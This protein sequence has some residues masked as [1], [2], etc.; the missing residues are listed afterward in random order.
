MHRYLRAWRERG[1][2]TAFQARIVNYADDFV[3]LSRGRATQALTWTRWGLAH[4]GLELSAE[5]TR[6]CNARRDGFD[7]LG[8]TFGPAHFRKDG[9]RY[10]AAQPARRA[11][12][13]LKE[14]VRAVLRAGIVSPWAEVRD[15]LNR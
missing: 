7:F 3:I 11:V 10:L 4:M 9:R 14:K 15:P 12:Q 5:K 2:G 8:Y 13:R 1:K 6:I